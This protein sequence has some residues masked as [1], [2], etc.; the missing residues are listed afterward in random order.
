MRA[1]SSVLV[2][3]SLVRLLRRIDQQPVEVVALRPVVP[4]REA[5]E[6]VSELV[7]DPGAADLRAD[8]T[9]RAQVLVGLLRLRYDDSARADDLP[10]TLV[11][12]VTR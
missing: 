5:I 12:Q 10:R 9:A 6:R 11:E 8:E 2:D 3:E 7:H 1:T 4:R